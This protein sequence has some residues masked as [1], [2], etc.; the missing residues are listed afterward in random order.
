MTI[1]DWS[2]SEVTDTCEKISS[3]VVT[4]P[5]VI[6]K[7]SVMLTDVE[8]AASSVVVSGLI[9][10]V[11]SWIAVVSVVVSGLIVVVISC[12]VVVSVVVH[13]VVTTVVSDIV[14]G[15][16]THLTSAKYF[17]PVHIT[18]KQSRFH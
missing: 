14:V 16:S 15:C 3:V 12:I 11:I 9:V 4:S 8:E 5:D 17:V 18:Y 10:V 13:S 7:T 1:V 6:G 2:D